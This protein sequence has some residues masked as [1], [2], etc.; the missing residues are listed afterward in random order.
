ME[1]IAVI[2][3]IHGNL[4]ALKKVLSDIE[5]RGIQKIICLGDVIGK[6]LHPH[7]CL[8]LIKENCY[9][10]LKGNYCHSILLDSTDLA[11]TS[12]EEQERILWCKDKLTKEDIEYIE[13]MPYCYE[14]YISGRLVRFFHATPENIYK[15]IGDIDSIEEHYGLFLPSQN[16][17]STNIADVVVYGHIHMQYLKRMYNRTIMNVGSVGNSIDVFRNKEKDGN[18]EN[19]TVA[20]Y[21]I[22]SGSLHSQTREEPFSFEF[23]SVPYDIEKELK[24]NQENIQREAYEEELKNGCYRSMDNVY[25]MFE[26]NGIDKDKI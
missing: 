11:K 6:G 22:L 8:N 13:K 26:L 16:T 17:I 20:N 9:V 2:S 3:D 19:T 24:T 1:R 5:T 25:K 21:L 14:L 18:I 4:E 7:E 23:V 12:K 15:V 10:A